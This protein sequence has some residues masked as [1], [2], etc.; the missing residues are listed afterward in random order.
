MIG[1]IWKKHESKK[2]KALNKVF[3]HL[4][5]FYNDFGD[6]LFFGV[7]HVTFFNNKYDKQKGKKQGEQI[8]NKSSE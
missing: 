1:N 4:S 8:S 5:C 3:R 2:L 7:I 6:R